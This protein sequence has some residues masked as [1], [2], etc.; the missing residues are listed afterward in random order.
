MFSFKEGDETY[1]MSFFYDQ[2]KE[3][4]EAK[5]LMNQATVD[6]SSGLYNQYALNLAMDELKDERLV[7]V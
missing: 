3:I 6:Q 7:F 1:I 5:E 4:D 2:T